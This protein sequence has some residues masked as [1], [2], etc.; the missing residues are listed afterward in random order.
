MAEP[1]DFLAQA[2]KLLASASTD[3]DYRAV[4]GRAYYGA[5]HAARQFEET[6]A[7]PPKLRKRAPMNGCSSA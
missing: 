3:P 7:K 5:F 2:V 4:I 1:E 6:V